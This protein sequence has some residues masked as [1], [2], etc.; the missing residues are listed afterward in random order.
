M[1]K[2]KHAAA[3]LCAVLLSAASLAM[4]TAQEGVVKFKNHDV[5]TQNV[6]QRSETAPAYGQE[7]QPICAPT[8]QTYQYC[9]P[10][11]CVPVGGRLLGR[12]RMRHFTLGAR[13]FHRDCN[14]ICPCCGCCRCCCCCWYS[15]CDDGHDDWDDWGVVDVLPDD[16][17]E[18]YNGG[19]DD[20]NGDGDGDGKGEDEDDGKLLA[21]I[22]FQRLFGNM[23]EITG[24]AY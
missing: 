19:K 9:E 11:A 22:D 10:I 20:G 4:A 7:L 21:G 18:D 3:T 2:M 15:N 16:V 8:V 6:A 24:V 12:L 14:G 17:A 13:I 1:T 5:Q 23:P